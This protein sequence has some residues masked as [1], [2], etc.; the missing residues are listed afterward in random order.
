MG[1]PTVSATKLVRVD[2]SQPLS[3]RVETGNAM[4][5][6]TRFHIGGFTGTCTTEE[7]EIPGG[8][9]LRFGTLHFVTTVE[10]NNTMSNRTSVTYH[11]RNGDSV[12]PF[13]FELVLPASERFAL[14]LI[15]ITFI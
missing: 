15:D 13:P 3:F 7:V 10:D 12:T 1:M 6:G 5:S 4:L 9:E 2:F 14:Y 8:S 11:L